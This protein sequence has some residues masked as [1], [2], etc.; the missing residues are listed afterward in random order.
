MFYAGLFTDKNLRTRYGDVITLKMD[1]KSSVIIPLEV[2]IG[3]TENES[4]TYYVA[5]TEKETTA[6]PT[7]RTPCTGERFYYSGCIGRGFPV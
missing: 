5:E 3:T 2:N 6:T 4:V 1:G 7:R